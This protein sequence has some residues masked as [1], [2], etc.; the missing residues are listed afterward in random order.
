M[1]ESENVSYANLSRDSYF[2]A[3]RQG[4][5]QTLD[6]LKESAKAGNLEELGPAVVVKLRQQAKTACHL[7]LVMEREGASRESMEECLAV[8]PAS[9]KLFMEAYL[10]WREVEPGEIQACHFL[11]EVFLSC[12]QPHQLKRYVKLVHEF[13]DLLKETAG[14]LLEDGQYVL[15]LEMYQRVPEAQLTEKDRSHLAGVCAY[16][17]GRFQAAEELLRRALDLGDESPEIPLFLKW[18]HESEAKRR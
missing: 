7:L 15:A 2:E 18:I 12:A 17:S 3:M 4:Q 9:L 5:V 8:M 14:I 6:M 13:P 16:H 10:G 11:R 1:V